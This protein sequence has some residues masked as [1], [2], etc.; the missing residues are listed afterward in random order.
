[1]VRLLPL[2][3]AVETT[4]SVKVGSHSLSGVQKVKSSNWNGTSVCPLDSADPE[5]QATEVSAVVDR[6]ELSL[7]VVGASTFRVGM[8]VWNSTLAGSMKLGKRSGRNVSISGVLMDAST[9]PRHR[10]LQVGWLFVFIQTLYFLDQ[11]F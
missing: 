6:T 8:D 2:H 9:F 7:W 10:V 3:S 1:M 5:T 11:D 4:S